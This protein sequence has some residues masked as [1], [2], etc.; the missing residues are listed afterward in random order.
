MVQRGGTPLV[1]LASAGAHV[2]QPHAGVQ[3]ARPG[4]LVQ[5]GGAL[6]IRS[7]NVHLVL[8]QALSHIQ[9][10]FGTSFPEVPFESLPL[11]NLFLP[12]S[13]GLFQLGL[14]GRLRLPLC[15][16]LAC[17][18]VSSSGKPVL[19]RPCSIATGLQHH[20]PAPP[21]G[22]SDFGMADDHPSNIKVRTLE[23]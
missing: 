1:D 8:H 20:S 21:E 10:S 17:W 18:L 12:L 14:C 15:P 7:R 3:V 23:N 2:Q 16:I 6:A 22:S 9:L 11:G 5:C 4:C 19:L 13:P